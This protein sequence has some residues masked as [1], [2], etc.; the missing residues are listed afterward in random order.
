MTVEVAPSIRTAL[1]KTL[2]ADGTLMGLCQGVF[3]G[4]APQGTVVPYC[5][6]MKADERPDW[7]FDGPS[8]DNE[9]WTVKGVGAAG[10]AEKIDQRC[11]EL[12]TKTTLKLENKTSLDCRYIHGFAYDEE[13]GGERWDHIGAEYRIYSEGES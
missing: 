10:D 7:C 6:V 5:I 13:S 11:R 3:Y 9:V 12:L 8:L 1:V 2:K 4:K